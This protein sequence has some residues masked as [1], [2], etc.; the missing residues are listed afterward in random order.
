MAGILSSC[1]LD[2]SRVC[3]VGQLDIYTKI[4]YLSYG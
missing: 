3:S 2:T 1:H 4:Y